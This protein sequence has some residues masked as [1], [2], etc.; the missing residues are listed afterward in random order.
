MHY[1]ATIYS[2]PRS[3]AVIPVGRVV[4]RGRNMGDS[5]TCLRRCR[6]KIACLGYISAFTIEARL[7]L[8]RDGLTARILVYAQSRIF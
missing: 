5:I 2:Y 4:Q 1:R 3:D 7:F 8:Q 6:V